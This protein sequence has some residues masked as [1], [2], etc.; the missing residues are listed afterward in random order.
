MS[1][2]IITPE[3]DLQLIYSEN[4]PP[5]NTILTP[6]A[7]RQSSGVLNEDKGILF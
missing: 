5:F 3:L 2:K 1:P 7:I 6:A 4:D